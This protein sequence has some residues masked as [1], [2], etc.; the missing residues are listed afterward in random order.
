MTSAS[1]T[2][3]RLLWTLGSRIART[4]GGSAHRAALTLAALLALVT[5]WGVVAAH[6]VH[7]RRDAR[8][9]ARNPVPV[10]ADAARARWWERPDAVGER[11][12]S[13]VYVRP[14]APAVHPPPGLPRWPEPGEAFLSPA[15]AEAAPARYGRPAGRISPAGLADG[16]ELVAYVNPAVDGFFDEVD[17]PTSFISGFGNRQHHMFFVSSHQFDRGLAELYLIVALIAGVPV[18]ALVLVAARSRSEVRE[19]RL[20]LLDALGI[21]VRGRAVVVAAE[22]ARPLGWGILGGCV[23]AL[24]VSVTSLVL[25]FTGYRVWAEDLRAALVWLPLCAAGTFAVLLGVS[26]AGC[27]VRRRREGAAPARP[28]AAGGGRWP[29]V[30]FVCAVVVAGWGSEHRHTEGKVAFAVGAMAALIVLPYATARLARLIGGRLARSGGRSG[31]AARIVAGRWLAARPQALARLSAALVVGLGIIVIGQ[32]VTTQFAGPAEAARARHDAAGGALIQVRSR[33]IPATADGFVAALGADRVVRYSPDPGGAGLRLT[34]TCRSLAALGAVTACPTEPVGVERSF[35]GLSPLGRDVLASRE[36]LPAPP[37]AVCACGAPV[38]GDKA[39]FGFIVVNR[40]GAA[41]VDAV[42]QA[43]YRHLIGPMTAQ[44]GQSWY[45]G[46][47][48][49]AAQVRWL[50]DVGL[51]GIAALAAAGA[52]GAAGVFIEQSQALGPLASYQTGRGF[53]R[54][55]AL[56]N[57]ALPLMAVGVV[58]VGAAALLGGLMI[59]LGKGGWM[60]VGLLGAGLTAVAVSGL[61]VAW[62]CGRTAAT[63]ASSWAPRAD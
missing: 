32:V 25:P 45:L 8:M 62:T 48:A 19:R 44:P 54:R 10:A 14:L 49:Q 41:G 23:P 55:I 26:V 17:E 40:D 43:A 7:D 6:T 39:L 60:S 38:E 16:T 29:G 37:V 21:P 46:S 47:A 36:M 50:L 56:Y 61:A 42:E 59:N 58:G 33:N 15:L 18:V 52:L 51:L 31:D 12:V 11:A 2:G 4:R 3:T 24:T 27:L 34:G 30:V 28:G 22:A 13:V 1:G 57:L 63:H 5:V 20:L 53:Y 35:A 9:T